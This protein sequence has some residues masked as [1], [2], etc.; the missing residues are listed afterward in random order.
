MNRS[1]Q[2]LCVFVWFRT[3]RHICI[4]CSPA[5]GV[6]QTNHK[7]VETKI[8]T[9]IC[10]HPANNWSQHISFTFHAF[11]TSSFSVI[12]KSTY[13]TVVLL[14][15]FILVWAHNNWSNRYNIY[16][17][18]SSLRICVRFF[19]FLF[20]LKCVEQFESSFR[21]NTWICP[22]FADLSLS[23]SIL[24]IFVSIFFSFSFHQTKF[25]SSQT[26]WMREKFT[27]NSENCIENDWWNEREHESKIVYYIGMI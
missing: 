3:Y 23:L 14:I 4:G 12:W 9:H 2:L 26:K 6:I 25:A 21:R 11:K 17:C 16:K 27:T 24:P 7:V 5:L 1:R 20:H 15:F 10:I 19:L 18:F 8:Q 13:S 22:T